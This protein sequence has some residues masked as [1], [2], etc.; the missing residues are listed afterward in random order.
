MDRLLT[1][2][3]LLREFGTIKGEK[4]IQKLIYLIQSHTHNLGY[5]FEWKK[6]GPVSESLG[7]DIL[8]AEILGY[9][10]ISWENSVPVYRCSD[11]QG[12]TKYWQDKSRDYS[13][14]VSLVK[15]TQ[16]LKVSLDDNKIN[17]PEIMQLLA[18]FD[19]LKRNNL[20]NLESFQE[21]ISNDN[22]LYAKNLLNK[23][24][25]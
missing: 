15:I 10:N 22:L 17:N 18:S 12:F 4:A 20:K 25:N 16:I 14:P 21:K 19:F 1:L 5:N 8:E 7:E 24:S 3:H 2:S 6:Y 23:L 13:L 9:I 11:S